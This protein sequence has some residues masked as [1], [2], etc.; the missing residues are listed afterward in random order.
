MTKLDVESITHE[1]RIHGTTPIDHLYCRGF[2]YLPHPFSLTRQRDTDD[3]MCPLGA[4][5]SLQSSSTMEAHFIHS[6]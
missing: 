3:T 6:L 2:G 5:S 4:E 1:E